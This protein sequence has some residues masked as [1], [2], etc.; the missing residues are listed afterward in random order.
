MN[1][2]SELAVQC[3]ETTA[4]EVCDSEEVWWLRKLCSRMRSRILLRTAEAFGL[5]IP[6]MKD[7]QSFN[8]EQTMAVAHTETCT[9]DIT[10]LRSGDVA[11]FNSCVDTTTPRNGVLCEMHPSEG[12]WL[13]KGPSVNNGSHENGGVFGKQA[14]CGVFP[15]SASRLIGDIQQCTK[16]TRP[17]VTD[18]RSGNIFVYKNEDTEKH[19][20]YTKFDEHFMQNL[21]EMSWHRDN[22]VTMYMPIVIGIF[23]W[24]VYW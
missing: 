2:T 22:E 9:H 15:T 8:L 21:Q 23:N 1:I 14:H 16:Q 3:K 11:V 10:S 24:P 12:F 4:G 13:F 17:F 6:V 20:H 19:M 18:F 5:K 7:V